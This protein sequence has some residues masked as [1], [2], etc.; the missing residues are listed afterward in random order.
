[1]YFSKKLCFY[2]IYLG[3]FN[4]KKAEKINFADPGLGIAAVY[5]VVKLAIQLILR[6]LANLAID[7][8]KIKI[9]CFANES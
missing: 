6:F 2:S 4:L 3:N 9:Q 5:V 8:F 1:M 7:H